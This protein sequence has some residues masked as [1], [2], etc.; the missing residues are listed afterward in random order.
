MKNINLKKILMFLIPIILIGVV[1]LKLRKNKTA[2]TEKV[3]QYDKNTPI[4]VQTKIAV[5]SNVERELSYTGTF[6]PNRETKLSA[7]VQGKINS[8][9][10][11]AGSYVKQ[12]QS[13]VKL[14]DALLKQ[15]LKT[16]EVMIQNLSAETEIQLQNNTIQLEGLEADV[17]RFKVLA[18]SEAIQ[19]VQLEKAE[20]QLKSVQ[21]QRRTLQQ[22]SAIKNAEA[23]R[24]SILEQ[25]KKTSIFA[26]F[27]GIVTAKLS[28]VGSFAGP[29]VPIVQLSE[30]G[31][32]K[33]VINVPESDLKRFA[34][35]QVFQV[36]SDAYNTLS[37]IA[38]VSM[39]GS[40][41]NIGSSF[42]VQFELQNT[43]DFKLKAGML[44]RISKNTNGTIK[45]II[46][47]AAV[48][49]GSAD[50]PKVYVVSDGKAVL[51]PVT[52]SSRI[53]NRVVIG[54]GITE[55]DEVI[56]A[57]FINLFEGAKVSKIK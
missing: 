49:Q 40:K 23:Q 18:A 37:F 13:L 9:F 42:P 28:E 38:K 41:A 32:L 56:V 16:A 51:K 27:S 7:E 44:G 55:G 45:G 35:G 21:N 2:A 43:S 6:E 3:Y 15:Q 48:L 34:I 10:V 24:A 25:I 19:G 4:E 14:D 26:P 39:I 52:I 1:V 17:Q 57:G 47:P 30:L 20:I 36:T 31:R 53:D 29:G 8:V 22:Q 54:S 5:K 12:G 50:N 11:D 46:L 33:F